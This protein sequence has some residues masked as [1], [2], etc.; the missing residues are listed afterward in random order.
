MNWLLRE[1]TVP[2]PLHYLHGTSALVLELCLNYGLVVVTGLTL[3]FMSQELMLPPA[4]RMLLIALA[5]DLAGGVISNFTTGTSQFYWQCAKRRSLFICLHVM[6]PLL[7]IWI[8]PQNIESICVLA[9]YTLLA[10][11]CVN[12]ITDHAAQKVVAVSLVT[13]GFLLLHFWSLPQLLYLAMTLFQIKL[14][15]SFAVKW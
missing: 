7:L 14:I 4:K 1:V 12:R 11:V 5:M 6:Q 10:A 2:R 9:L 15:L 8:F 3:F 13:M